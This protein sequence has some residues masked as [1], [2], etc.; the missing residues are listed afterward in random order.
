M[1]SNLQMLLSLLSAH[2]STLCRSKDEAGISSWDWSMNG[3]HSTYHALF[4]R[5]WTIY[6]GTAILVDEII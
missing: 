2:G 5:A 6:E 4:P 3:Q 1:F